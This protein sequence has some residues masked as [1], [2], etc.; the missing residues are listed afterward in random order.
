MYLSAIG[1][2]S[3]AVSR[4]DTPQPFSLDAYSGLKTR[5][6]ALSGIGSAPSAFFTFSALIPTV[7]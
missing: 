5:S 2:T 7:V 3:E 1:I 6:H 4:N